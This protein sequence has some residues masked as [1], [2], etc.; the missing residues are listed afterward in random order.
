MMITN[1]PF[2][3][4][5]L[6]CTGEVYVWESQPFP[7][8]QFS[9]L[10]FCKYDNILIKDEVSPTVSVSLGILGNDLFR[11]AAQTSLLSKAHFSWRPRNAYTAMTL[12]FANNARLSCQIKMHWEKKTAILRHNRSFNSFKKGREN[13]QVGAQEVIIHWLRK[14]SK[15]I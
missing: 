11:V 9:L 3:C 4:M 14:F 2:K 7:L 10:P 15:Q 6:V 1:H 12:L 8:V 13:S 5:T